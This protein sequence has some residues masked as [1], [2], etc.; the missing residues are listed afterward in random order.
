[1]AR[2]MVMV[3][4]VAYSAA[5]GASSV[6]AGVVIVTAQGHIVPLSAAHLVIR[7]PL[8]PRVIK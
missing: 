2:C 3:N 1:M 5:P 8:G 4:S 7:G 6:A